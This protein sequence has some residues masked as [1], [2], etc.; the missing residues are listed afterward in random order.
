MATEA[1]DGKAAA[2]SIPADAE[3]DAKRRARGK[4]LEAGSAERS[5]GKRGR[6]E[7]VAEG[8]AGPLDDSSTTGAAAETTAIEVC[9]VAKANHVGMVARNG[10]AIK[11]VPVKAISEIMEAIEIVY[12]AEG[13]K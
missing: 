6:P 10:V 3:T 13:G 11:S 1:T 9:P 8:I 5:L 2:E 7:R 12:E 4:A